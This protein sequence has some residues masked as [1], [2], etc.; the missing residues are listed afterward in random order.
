VR[1]NQHTTV[2]THPY[3]LTR[4][5]LD[6]GTILGNGIQT[7][8]TRDCPG[9]RDQV[10]FPETRKRHAA[11]YREC[12]QLVQYG[13]TFNVKPIG[14]G[15]ANA[16]ADRNRSLADQA[17]PATDEMLLPQLDDGIT[18]LDVEGGPRRPDPTVARAR[19]PPPTRRARLLGRRKRARNDDNAAP[20]SPQ[21]AVARPDSCRTWVHRLPTLRRRL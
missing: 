3:W 2:D 17:D 11:A 21:P 1:I 16:G 5:T 12:G 18:L 13:R 15:P 14:S 4:R 8:I 10:E 6:S 9:L 19:P 7:E 20:R